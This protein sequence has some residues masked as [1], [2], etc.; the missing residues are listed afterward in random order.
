MSINKSI[1]IL[2]ICLCL[3]LIM[4]FG[5]SVNAVSSANYASEKSTRYVQ[6]FSDNI[7][8][9]GTAGSGITWTLDNNGLLVFSGT[10]AMTDYGFSGTGTMTAYDYEAVTPPWLDN[11]YIISSVTIENGITTIG[12]SAFYKCDTLESVSIPESVEK[13]ADY[14]FCGCTAMESIIIPGGVEYIGR[15]AFDGCTILENVTLSDGI[16][17]IG[18]SAFSGCVAIQS[19]TIP[20]SVRTIGSRAFRGC[21]LKELIIYKGLESIGEG[22]FFPC[23]NLCNL[24]YSGTED[25]WN[26][27]TMGYANFYTID[28]CVHFNSTGN[29]VTWKYNDSILSFNGEGEMPG[30]RDGIVPPWM[31][32]ENLIKSVVI[33]DG[34][35]SIGRFAFYECD[36]LET[37]YI[38]KSIKKI[39]RAA[40]YGCFELRKIFYAG[41]RDDWNEISIDS[42]NEHL[43]EIEILFNVEPPSDDDPSHEP[44]IGDVNGSGSID[45]GDAVMLLRAVIGLV[46]LTPEQKLIA[47]VNNDSA[48][49][50]GDAITVLRIVAGI[51][52]P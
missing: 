32:D 20:G 27:V 46:E 31:E 52:E 13:I 28:V 39:D 41:S 40:F 49:N 21:D 23:K 18:D 38:P 12:R 22:A 19:I 50:T 3:S 43:F 29:K 15:C 42:F 47:D 24:Y 25:D 16:Q 5:I 51:I 2:L 37:I 26:Q 17:T 6:L 4:C 9:S 10:G 14:A 45:T 7:I 44:I 48:I 8:D 11:G 30:Y 33:A 1:F 36:T 35:T 34:I